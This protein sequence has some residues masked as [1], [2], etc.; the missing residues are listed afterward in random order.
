MASFLD[1]I[2]GLSFSAATI[3]VVGLVLFLHVAGAVM[4]YLARNSR[5][6]M[7]GR[8]R[9]LL[10]AVTLVTLTLLAVAAAE[11]TYTKQEKKLGVVM[12]VDGSASIPDAE[13]DRARRWVEQAYSLAQDEFVRTIVFGRDPQMLTN[14]DAGAPPIERPAQ[15]PGSHLDRALHAA[16]D[17]FPENITRRAVLLTDGNQTAG[18]LAAEASL[19]A[20]HGI[21]LSTLML[22]T[23]DDRDLYVESIHIP[24]AARPGERVKVGVV[25][26][27]N[28]ATAARLRITQG[29]KAVFNETVNILPGRN[30]FEAESTVSGVNAATFAAQVDAADDQHPDNNRLAATLRISARPRVVLFGDNV[31]ADLALVEALNNAGLSVKV[32]TGNKIPA[33]IGPLLGFD[34][35]ILSDIKYKRLSN[36][37]QEALLEYAKTGGGGVL[38]I[39]GPNSGDLGKKKEKLP[40]KRMMPV[41]FKEKKKTEP[42]PV[43]LILVIDKSASMARQ[44]KFAMAVQA[45]SDTIDLLNERSRLGVILFDD[46]PRWA[47]PLQKVGTEENKEKMKQRLR[48]FGVD[49]GTSIYPAV[50]EAYKKL[51]KDKAKVKHIILLS[52]GISITTFDQWGHVV[53]W[54]ASKKITISTVALGQESDRK[55]LRKIAEVGRGRFYYTE[56]FMQIPRI[57]LEETKTIAKTNIVEKKIRPTLLKKGDL[58]E[59]LNLQR[60]PDLAGYNSALPKP[61]SEVFMTADRNEPL[62]VRWRFGLGRVSVL[63]TDSGGKW[64]TKWRNWNQY[65]P[66]M[67]KLVR[68]TLADLALRNYRITADTD[69]EKARLAVDVT[70][71]YGNFV[72][73][74]DLIVRVTRPEADDGE[75]PLEVPLSQVRAGGYEGTFTVKSFGTHALRVAPQSGALARAQGVGQVHLTPPRE[76]VA[77]RPDRALLSKVAAIGRGKFNPQPR[78]LFAE[79]EMEYPQ[80]KALWNYLLYVALGMMLVAVIIRRS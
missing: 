4:I 16:I 31:D 52:D 64:A 19:A 27:S 54:M 66:L 71:Q 69:D 76:F 8:R 55:H 44:R 35:V 5:L 79:P 10:V 17:L 32:A 61:T 57:F 42:N 46:F 60:I 51:K 47:I 12:L 30:A 80:R 53:Q 72:N 50:S 77:T 7:P 48:S 40:I 24:A 1:A 67:T 20:V 74:L 63:A 3:K 21:E 29:G 13:F 56:D 38:V 73:D 65:G 43:T 37:Q 33:S 28:F 18:D 6:M 9:L 70:D 14:T 11:L 68:G 41:I 75:K 15:K 2:S 34:E 45:A 58:L 23:R 36:R 78:D 39:G 25:V 62:L 26:V 49:G 22:D 59:G